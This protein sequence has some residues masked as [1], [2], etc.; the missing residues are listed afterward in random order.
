MSNVLKREKQ[1]RA[2]HLLAEGCSIRGAERLTRVHR[3]TIMRLM[4]RFGNGCRE[5]L[6]TE[7]RHLT[8]R[9]IQVDEMHTYVGIRQKNLPADDKATAWDHGE[10]YLW[11]GIDQQ[12]KLVPTFLVGKR[13]A[14]NARRF[15]VDL[16]SRFDFPSPGQ[17]DDHAYTL[18]AFK[19]V[20]QISTDAFAGYR[21]ATDLSFGPFAKYGQVKKDFRNAERRPGD[22]SPA[23]IVTTERRPIRN[24]LPEE[25]RTICTSHVERCNL[26]V[27][28]L[29]KRFNRLTIC[30][31]KKL[32]NLEAAV[33]IFVAFYNYTW[34]PRHKGKSGR[35]R[36]TP[37]MAAGITE[38]LWTFE[39]LFDRIM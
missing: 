4:V 28:T 22:Y 38:R 39:E 9:H 21:E 16:A 25:I 26:T 33:A 15:M 32:T 20:V 18:G 24:L 8:V 31:S 11:Y 29:L 14:D 36:P 12:T 27:R 35:K 34:R 3:D 13:S 5:F 23:E 2:L 37:A 6:N 17:A 1:L 10:V 30:Y 7:M 19:P